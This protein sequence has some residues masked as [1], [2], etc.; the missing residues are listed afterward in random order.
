M[1]FL[2]TYLC[3]FHQ[4][5]PLKSIETAKKLQDSPVS[6]HEGVNKPSQSLKYIPGDQL[7]FQLNAELMLPIIIIVTVMRS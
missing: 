7:N 5:G 2:I 6:Q 3:S 1:S 4:K